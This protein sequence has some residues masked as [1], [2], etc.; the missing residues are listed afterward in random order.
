[1]ARVAGNQLLAPM[2]DNFFSFF[3]AGSLARSQSTSAL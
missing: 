1:M 2:A 3:F